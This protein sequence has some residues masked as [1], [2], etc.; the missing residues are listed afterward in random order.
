MPIKVIRKYAL[1]K[2]M[3]VQ[4]GRNYGA[5]LK[6]KR[7]KKSY[8]SAAKASMSGKGAPIAKSFPSFQKGYLPFGNDYYARLP[9]V[10]TDFIEANGTLGT[11]VARQY[12]ANNVFRP[13]LTDVS[14][15][16]RQPLQYYILTATYERVWVH[17]A[18]VEL[19]FTN[20]AADGMYCGYRV[21]SQTNTV[22]STGQSL[23]RMLEMR[24]S[25]AVPINDSGSQT[26]TFKFF[27]KNRDVFGVSKNQYAD[28]TYSHVTVADPSVVSFIEP[29]A[30]HTVAGEDITPIRYTMKIVYYCQFT[31][32]I[33]VNNPTV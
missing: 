31:N 8:S 23:A 30:L 15:G 22:L 17:G 33:T 11:S 6:R 29:W 21:R 10:V 13:V 3:R 14:P 32:P 16:I 5:M 9:F 20:P 1:A 19:T 4:V 28:L 27:V 2:R 12:H 18:H 7:N 24:D 25:H 26:H